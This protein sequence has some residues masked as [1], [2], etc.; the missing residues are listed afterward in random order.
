[1]ANNPTLPKST[2]AG[3]FMSGGKEAR[4]RGEH[5]LRMMGLEGLVLILQ[6]GGVYYL[7][8][9]CSE[10]GYFSIWLNVVERG[11]VEP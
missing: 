9:R 11:M 6:V 2:V 1:M 8:K 3:D 4:E 7:L 5:S 10:G